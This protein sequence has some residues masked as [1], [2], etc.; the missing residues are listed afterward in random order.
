MF[1][2]CMEKTATLRHGLMVALHSLVPLALRL[3]FGFSFAM[4]GWMKFTMIPKVVEG[5]TAAGIP[6]AG[7]LAPFVAGVELVGGVLLI[8]GLCTR[9]ASFFLAFTMVVALMT[10]HV[11]AFSQGLQGVMSAPPFSFL[12]ATLVLLTYGAGPLSVDFWRKK[13]CFCGCGK[14]CCSC[15]KK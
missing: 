3:I 9:V 5:F 13:K 4:A 15:A 12:V 8:A 7:V 14:S 6:F 1:K 2:A 11:S 10:A